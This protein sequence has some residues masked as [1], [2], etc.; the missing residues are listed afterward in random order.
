MVP[1]RAIAAGSEIR[2][3]FLIPP[4][5]VNRGDAVHVEVRSGAAR[6]AFTAKA[7]SGGRSGDFIAVRNP[8]S[9]KIFRARIE[10]KDKVVVQT[11][12]AATGQ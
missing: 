2:P 12:F 8:S 1:A 3:E 11:E 6:L 7:E 4:N 9:N 5:D 10:G